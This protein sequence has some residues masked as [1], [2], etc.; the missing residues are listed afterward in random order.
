MISDKEYIEDL[1]GII[2]ILAKSYETNA[3]TFFYQHLKTCSNSNPN[4]RDLTKCEE[5]EI[6]RFSLFE[7]RLQNIIK[8]FAKKDKGN[9]KNIEETVKRY[10]TI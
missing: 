1:E 4:R 3:D 9:P 6:S 2:N 10:E 5:S 8:K 7:G